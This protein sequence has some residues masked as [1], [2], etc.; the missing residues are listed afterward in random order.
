[1]SFHMLL[2]TSQPAI[3]NVSSLPIIPGF[4]EF[5]RK[6]LGFRRGIR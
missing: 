6:T 1:M 5:G 2:E 3:L 4:H